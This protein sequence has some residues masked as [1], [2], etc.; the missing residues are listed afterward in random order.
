MPRIDQIVVRTYIKGIS[1]EM[2]S[3]MEKYK[4]DADIIFPENLWSEKWLMPLYSDCNVYS[5]Y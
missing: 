3:L 1:K 5:N 4:D 2:L